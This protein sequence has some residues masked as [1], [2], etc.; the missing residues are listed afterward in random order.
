MYVRA[1]VSG[2]GTDVMRQRDGL[3]DRWRGGKPGDARSEEDVDGVGEAVAYAH[4]CDAGAAPG[5]EDHCRLGM[6]RRERHASGH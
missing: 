6:G 1:G 2:G 4:F 3:G 5:A